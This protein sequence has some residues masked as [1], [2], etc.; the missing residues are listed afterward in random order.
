MMDVAVKEFHVTNISES[1]SNK[2]EDRAWEIYQKASLEARVMVQLHHWNILGLV[3]VTVWP[4][5]LL[6]ELAPLGDI[7]SCVAKFKKTSIRL[8][9]TTIKATL[10]QVRTAK[11]LQF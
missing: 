3:G 10:V 11:Q 8:M 5:R 6:V 1:H 9:K 4:L 7:K 2:E